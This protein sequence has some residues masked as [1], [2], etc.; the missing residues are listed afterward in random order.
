[1]LR[2]EEAQSLNPKFGVGGSFGKELADLRFT[3]Y[4]HKKQKAWNLARVVSKCV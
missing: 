3:I 4:D 2:T 1:M